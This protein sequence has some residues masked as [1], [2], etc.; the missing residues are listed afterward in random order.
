MGTIIELALCSLRPFRDGDQLDI[1]RHANN[2]K[3]AEHLR[4][5][6]PQPYTRANADAWISYAER[7]SPLLD[8]A[9]CVE[10]RVVGGIGLMPGEDIHRISAE[11]GYWLGE[12]YWGRGI[13]ACAL[14]GLTR[15]AFDTHRD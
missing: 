4:E 7:K 9:V 8:F 11:V 14:Q 3:V 2:P 6:F 5:R 1:V 10:D 15:Y 13:A 12:E